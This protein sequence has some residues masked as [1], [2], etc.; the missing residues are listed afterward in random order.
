MPACKCMRAL[1]SRI[2]LSFFFMKTYNCCL[3]SFSNFV[4]VLIS[5]KDNVMSFN[6]VLNSTRG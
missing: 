3:V 1:L 6:S 2:S 4:I 5:Y